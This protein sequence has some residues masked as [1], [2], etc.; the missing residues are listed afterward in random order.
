[1]PRIVGIRED[2]AVVESGYRAE[3]L[4]PLGGYR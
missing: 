3:C 2:L 4:L 1:M